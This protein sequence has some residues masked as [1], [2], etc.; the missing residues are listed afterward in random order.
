MHYHG[1][2]VHLLIMVFGGSVKFSCY[3]ARFS[4]EPLLELELEAGIL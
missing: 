1:L 4:R 3:Q 2:Q